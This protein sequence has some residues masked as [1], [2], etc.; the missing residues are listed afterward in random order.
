MTPA[1]VEPVALL[2]GQLGYPNTSKEVAAR[3]TA[4]V[5]RSRHA[6][7]IAEDASRIFGWVHVQEMLTLETGPFADLGGLVVA[8]GARGRGVGRLLVD[9]AEQWAIA[10]GYPEMRVRSNVIRN[11]AHEFYAHLGYEVIKTQLNFRK[12]LTAHGR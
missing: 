3:F 2:C 1:D 4:L 9:A 5:G 10:R 11:E 7:F 8:D 12:S 6:I